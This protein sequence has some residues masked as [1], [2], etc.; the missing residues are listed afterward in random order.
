MQSEQLRE[1]APDRH[2][3]ALASL[4][5]AN[6]DDPLGE[7]DVLGPDLDKL[8]HAGAHLQQGLQQE[9]GP[10]VAD[11]GLIDEP[12][13]FLDRQAVD[14]GAAIGRRL[15]AGPLPGG[16]EHRLAL[17]IIEALPDQDG[18]DRRDGAFDRTHDEFAE[19][20]SGANS[21]PKYPP[22]GKTDRHRG[23]PDRSELSAPAVVESSLPP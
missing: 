17:K 3:P 18:S 10:A 9:P 2:F 1:L 13:L 21:W 4:A 8:R 15:Q 19:Q 22:L 14:R 6:D 23:A 20:G 12:Q 5:P 11:I 16:F 7:A